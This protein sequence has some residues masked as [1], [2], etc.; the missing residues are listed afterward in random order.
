[1]WGR[2][3]GWCRLKTWYNR[4]VNVVTE[5]AL[6]NAEI[7]ARWCGYAAAV[8]GGDRFRREVIECL[9]VGAKPARMVAELPSRVADH[10]RKTSHK[11]H[12]EREGAPAGRPAKI[13]WIMSPDVM[14]RQP[15]VLLTRGGDP[16]R[17]RCAR[18]HART[19]APRDDALRLQ[20]LRD[21]WVL[22]Q[23]GAYV[24]Q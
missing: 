17:A 15:I 7:V 23:F 3:R 5:I 18:C 1:M 13:A 9:R 10:V 16:M 11:Q 12:H 8:M 6:I 19:G 2:F 20:W 21:F 14:R 4:I 24:F 22:Y